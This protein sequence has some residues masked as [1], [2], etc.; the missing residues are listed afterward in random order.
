MSLLKTT[1]LQ[2]RV[3]RCADLE[4]LKELEVMNFEK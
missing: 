3:R 1:K 4:M 2:L